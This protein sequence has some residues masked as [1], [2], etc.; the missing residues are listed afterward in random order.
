MEAE[1]LNSNQSLVKNSLYNVAY[2]LLNVIF[3]LVSATYI[4]RVIFAKGVG[5][6]SYAQNIV[7]YF[8]TIAALGIPNYGIREIAKARKSKQ[9]TDEV[10][11]ELFTI[12][13]VSTTVC[14]VA[15]FMLIHFVSALN[16]N[17]R[18]YYAVGLLLIFNYINVDW[19]YQGN[20]EYGYIAKRSFVIKLISLI[21]MFVF[22]RHESDAI[23]YALISSLATG[24]NNVFNI[25][26][27]KKY[28]LKTD[29]GKMNVKRHL[30]PIF[31]MLGSVIAV[32]LY[33]M[34]DTTMIG[35]LCDSSSVGYYT[36]SMKLIKLLITVV[37]AIGGVLLPRLSQYYA[38]GKLNE[39]EFIV[40]KVFRVML[41]LFVPCEIGI[42][43]TA[44]LIMPV[45][46]GDSF[47]PAVTTLKIA[48]LLIC[49]LGF[50]NLFGTQILLTFGEEKKLLYCT[51]LGAVSNV[52]MNAILIPRYQQNGAAVASVISETLVTVMAFVFSR[53]Y[54]KI[55][56]TSRYTLSVCL[57]SIA[58]AVVVVMVM[59]IPTNQF[60]SLILSVVS[61]AICYLAINALTKNPELVELRNMIGKKRKAKNV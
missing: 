33:T 38:E 34:L 36:N 12:N 41:F 8:T 43:L 44:P 29:F 13:A 39:C 57:S 59:K 55:H 47:I 18:M 5:E 6:V 46:F 56:L 48:A 40:N 51:I 26:H 54:I 22:V 31:I 23:A 53:K 7:S 61:G 20:E 21:A 52:I 24:G 27:L 10:F 32:E 19:F 9:Q 25:I 28:N 2:K 42:I 45:M 30:K 1:P 16:S 35:I 4:A 37:T 11:F 3:P 14:I 49:T 50:S 58:M 15:Y 60:V 17:I